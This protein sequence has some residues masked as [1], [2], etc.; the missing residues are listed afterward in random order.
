MSQT[1]KVSNSA[2]TMVA[3]VEMIRRDVLIWARGAGPIKRS[4]TV[5]NF[6][7]SLYND[8]RIGLSQHSAPLD[9]HSE[10]FMREQVLLFSATLLV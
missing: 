1:V 8:Y 6:E 9:W 5:H 10:N 7:N 4:L 3:A 2:K